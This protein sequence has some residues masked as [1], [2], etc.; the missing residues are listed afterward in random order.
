M[1]IVVT[2]LLRAND[3]ELIKEAGHL[4]PPTPI[5]IVRSEMNHFID[6]NF[7]LEASTTDVVDGKRVQGKVIRDNIKMQLLQAGINCPCTLE[8]IYLVSP[9]GMLAARAVN[10]D[11]TKYIWD[12][13]DYMT[14]LLDFVSKRRY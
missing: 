1:V 6:R 9:P 14:G 10:F 4:N 5:M 13:F 8:S 11:G 3:L 12:E 7:G 2:E